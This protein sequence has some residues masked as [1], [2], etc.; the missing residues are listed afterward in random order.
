MGKSANRSATNWFRTGRIIWRWQSR[1]DFQSISKINLAK[2]FQRGEMWTSLRSRV[3][4]VAIYTCA[5]FA[6][7]FACA[8]PTLTQEP[9]PQVK[10]ETGMVEGKM[11]GTVH[12]FLGIPYAASTAGEQR[13]K[14]PAPAPSWSG[15]RKATEF[16]PHCMQGAIYGDMVFHDAGPSEDC[17]SLNVW[18]P[19]KDA[20]AKLAVM[21]WIYGGG[22]MA[23]ATSER[24]QDGQFLAKR[25]V[26]V[27][28]MNY[29]L[30]VFGFLVLPELAA[31]SGRNSSGNYGLLDQLAAL[32][33]V[34]RN[35]AAFGGDPDN[36][37][38]FG[39][40]A[41]SFSV[42][43][44]MASP[45]AHGLFVKAIGQSGA[46]F[47]AR[48]L[49][50]NS[51]AERK[52]SD[53]EFAKPSL[54]ST[55]LKD[56]RAIPAQKVLD[57]SL[58][59][60]GA[61]LRFA[62]SVD[63]YFL[64][65]SVPAIFAAGKENRVSLLAGWNHDE[66]GL[67][68]NV[69]NDPP[70]AAKLQAIAKK[71]FPNNWQEFLRLYP[72]GSDSEATR[73]LMDFNGDGFIAWPTWRWLEA[74][75]STGKPVYRYRFDLSL[76]NDVAGKPDV[77][78]YHSA[79]IEYVFGTLDSKTVKPWRAE[80][81]ALSDLMQIY[82]SNFARNGDPNATGLPVW[83]VYRAADGWPVMHL[84]VVSKVEKDRQRERYIFLTSVWGK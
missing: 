38:I 36:V 14:P 70:P 49:T 30:G 73:S 16:G 43:A 56:L 9:G 60:G 71:N 3:L 83:P 69:L 50:F 21:V 44:L 28:S 27:V 20:G 77:G 24:R 57:E 76:P 61:K 12:T 46:A 47:A 34:H 40:S 65:E 25:G 66:N 58:K 23:G 8:P 26:V 59:A 53:A 68:E 78:A 18:T 62:P 22:Y 72:S 41:G 6:L 81:R 17:L 7:A 64:P 80:D 35:I 31:E 79:E 52:Q 84:D 82:W 33:W 54:G 39:E 32:Q 75:A 10:I 74:A 55:S 42:S 67:L 5:V 19:A 51:L 63:G 48:G 11:Q 45:L 37:T 2:I 15:T 29:R 13:W 1:P 4:A